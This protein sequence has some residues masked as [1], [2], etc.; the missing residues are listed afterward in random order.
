LLAPP[1]S[2]SHDPSGAPFDEDFVTGTDVGPFECFPEFCART[3]KVFD[4]HSGPSGENP[5]G[6]VRIDIE[7][8]P[9]GKFTLDTGPV[10]C[11]NVAGNRA[12]VGARFLN[13]GRGV[14]FLEDNNGA[15]EDR[16]S[17]GPPIP[18][19]DPSV[20]PA[21]PSNA[22][23]P[24]VDG[25]ITVHDAPALPTSKD[26]CKRGG[27]RNFGTRFKNEGQCVA[28]VQHGPKP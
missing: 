24:I 6:T 8:N 14:F 2:G 5:T 21:T 17:P 15:G 22:L 7:T 26:Q 9:P 18:T 4:A 28:F 10:T 25:D 20:C 11:L 13:V 27:W 16:S 3:I 23:S 19:P 12:T 1:A